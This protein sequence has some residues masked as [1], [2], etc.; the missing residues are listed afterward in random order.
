MS[1]AKTQFRCLLISPGDVQEERDALSEVF[2]LWNAH[3]G[4]S[5]GVSVELNR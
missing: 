4:R 1:I 5:F 2:L 3:E